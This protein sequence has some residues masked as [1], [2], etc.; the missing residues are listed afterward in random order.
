MRI[1]RFIA[2]KKLA[3]CAAF[4]LLLAMLAAG[5]WVRSGN[6][7]DFFQLHYGRDPRADLHRSYTCDVRVS[8]G[9]MLV[10]FRRDEFE[11]EFFASRT[12]E[13]AQVFRAGFRAGFD[14]DHWSY[15]PSSVSRD[16]T[17]GFGHEYQVAHSWAGHFE[18][19]RI[20]AFPLWLPLTVFLI[21]P[22]WWLVRFIRSLRRDRTGLCL[23]CGY[24]LRATPGRCPE[25]G[26]VPKQPAVA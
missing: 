22:A 11:P 12:D 6:C 14:S 5:T 16:L 26:A 7:Y 3:I 13:G 1:I 23:V 15:K 17:H 10:Q 4:S 21:V 2:R 20:V 9:T 24:D 19:V 8:L 18:D 25:C